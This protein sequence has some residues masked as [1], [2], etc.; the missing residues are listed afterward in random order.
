MHLQESRCFI[1]GDFNSLSEAWGYEGADR[2]GE[3]AEDWQVD[4]G[5]VLL[6]D[7]DDP[8]TFISRRWLSSTTPVATNDL[9]GIASR[10]VLSQLG[11]S[12]HKP[13]KISLDLQYRTQKT[14]TFPRWNY[15]KANWERLSTLVDQFTQ[16]IN[17]K[18]QNLN[19]KTKAFNQAVLKAAQES[20]PRGNRKNYKP[21]WTEELQQQEDAVRE[22]RNLVE[23]SPS[24][25]NNVSLKAASTKHQRTLIQT[26]RK[27]CHEKTEQLNLDREGKKLWNLVAALND[28]RQKSSQII[29]EQE[30]NLCAGKQATNILVK[31][32]AETSD[33]QVPTDRKRETREEQHAG[34]VHQ[35]EQTMNSPFVTKELEDALTMLKLRKAPGPDNITN[36]MLLHLGP[37]S[38]KKLLQLF[39]DG[40][41]TG[42]VPQVG[43]ELIMIPILNRGKDK[44]KA[45]NYRPVSLTSCVGKLVESLINTRLMWHLEDKKHITSQQADFRQDRY[46]EDQIETAPAWCCWVKVHVDWTVHASNRRATVQIKQHLSKKRTLR[47]GVPQG[48]VLSP[49][50]FLIFIHDILHRMPKNIQGAIY[51]DDLALWRCEEYITTANYRL[52]QALQVI[53]S[54][55]WPWL[56]K[57]NE[58]KTFYNLHLSSQKYSVHLKL[59]GQTLRQEDAPT[60]LGVTLDRRLTWKNLLQKNQ[61]RANIRLALMKKTVMHRLGYWSEC[62]RK[63]LCWE[64][65]PSSWIW[66]GSKLHRCKIKV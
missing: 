65:P 47:Q 56:V 5:L 15:K 32:Y 26:A 40:W 31:Q 4:N 58:K 63:A 22:A 30:G 50:L 43:R 2:R 1:L 28:E 9:S 57:L 23:Q 64:T 33:L 34:P 39:N 24:E 60:Y 36:E 19:T 21:Y 20:I 10:T 52:Q 13:I 66:N 11:G 25:E 61:A 6:N 29:L 16:K 59:N 35:E 41:R 27:T 51:A 38:K 37:H 53:E 12:D 45:D 55:A 62:A 14:S 54:L 46:T 49:T 7:P 17:N 42:T 8:P 48:G 44:S 18:R 3:E